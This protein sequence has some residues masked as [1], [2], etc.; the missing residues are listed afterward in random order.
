MGSNKES[1]VIENFTF[2][3]KKAI[4]FG[5]NKPVNYKNTESGLTLNINKE[6]RND[7]DTIIEV[8]VF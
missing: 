4:Y 1:F 5:T 7:I 8:D 6:N 2:K 3:I